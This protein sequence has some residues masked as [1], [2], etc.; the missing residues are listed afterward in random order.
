MV[1]TT[2]NLEKRELGSKGRLNEYRRSGKVPGIL[3]GPHEKPTPIVVDEKELRAALTSGHTLLDAKLGRS[4][5]Q[6]VIREVQKHPVRGNFLHVDLMA[7]TTGEKITLTVPLVLVGTPR[8]V[9]DQGGTLL[10]ELHE[11]EIECLPK[12]VPEKIEV[13]VSELG[14]GQSLHISDIKIENITF[15]TPGDALVAHVVA[16]RVA[17]EAAPAAEEVVAEEG[18][19]AEEAAPEAPPAEGQEE[20]E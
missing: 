13:D 16:P 5:K 20:K 12:D 11:V 7:V 9:K 4:K 18:A 15:V 2:L 14:V 3:Y 1:E 17:A 19:E 10:H 8:G 6:V